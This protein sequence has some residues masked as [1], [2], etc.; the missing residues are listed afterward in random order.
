MKDQFFRFMDEQGLS[1]RTIG[2]YN[3]GLTSRIRDFAKK[4]YKEYESGGV[5]Y[6]VGLANAYDEAGA[7]EGIAGFEL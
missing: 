7:V 2:N 1:E 6:G 3:N 4:Y 5:K